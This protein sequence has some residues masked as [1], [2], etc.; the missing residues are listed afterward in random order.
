MTLLK[1]Q[2]AAETDLP[3]ETF[4]RDP[5]KATLMYRA[6]R[7]GV[8]SVLKLGFGLEAYGVERIPKTGGLLM[9]SNHASYL[10]PPIVS[11]RVPRPMA[12]LAKSELF[13]WGPFGWTIRRL[14]AFP[15]KQ[16]KGDVGAMKESI[17]L[18]KAGWLLNVFPEG[19]RTPDGN[20]QP[21]QKGAGLMIRRAGVPVLPAVIDGSYEAWPLEQK[22]PRPRKLR[23][24]YGEAADISHL[25]AD[26]VRKWIDDT[27]ARM[28][29]DLRSGRV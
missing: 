4:R 2:P 20:L 1:D 7:F 10:D 16:G 24:L 28:R 6:W 12:F 11:V 5:D 19:G 17:R 26:D 15:V 22:Y 18:L 23:I 8:G 13:D 3:P 21:A 14:N 25:K 9:L 27:W 29:D